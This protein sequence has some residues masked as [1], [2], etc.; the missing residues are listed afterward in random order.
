ML[1]MSDKRLRHSLPLLHSPSPS[2]PLPQTSGHFL[3]GLP[4][5]VSTPLSDRIMRRH[6][7]INLRPGSDW[8][9]PVVANFNINR[10]DA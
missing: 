10:R 4:S 1:C 6:V 8:P 9:Q 7:L 3:Y 5:I 2:S